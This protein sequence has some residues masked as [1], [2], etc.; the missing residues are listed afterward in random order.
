MI[1]SIYNIMKRS[2]TFIMFILTKPS[3]MAPVTYGKSPKLIVDKI[4]TNSIN[5]IFLSNCK[6]GIYLQQGGMYEY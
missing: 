3:V 1:Y 5:S 6:G 4:I 2:P